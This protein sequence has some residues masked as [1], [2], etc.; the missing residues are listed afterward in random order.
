[1][2]LLADNNFMRK[3]LLICHFLEHMSLHHNCLL[4][5]ACVVRFNLF[6]MAYGILL[7]LA[8]IVPNPTLYTMSGEPMKYVMF[9]KI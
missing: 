2:H 4:I 8:P 3:D 5:S 7:F 9:N 1:M 6:S